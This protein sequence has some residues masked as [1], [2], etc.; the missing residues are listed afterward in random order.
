MRD[1]NIGGNG[2]IKRKAGNE[3]GKS[4]KKN[5][6]SAEKAGLSDYWTIREF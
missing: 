5:A 1:R 6:K 2:I 4:S 3:R